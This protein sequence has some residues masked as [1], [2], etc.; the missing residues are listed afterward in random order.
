MGS[1]SDDRPEPGDH[2]LPSQAGPSELGNPNL[3]D[4]PTPA[5]VSVP[6]ANVWWSD[7]ANA[8]LHLQRLR[9]DEV[10]DAAVAPGRA[11]EQRSVQN[12]VHI[13]QASEAGSVRSLGHGQSRALEQRFTALEQM[14]RPGAEFYDLTAADSGSGSAELYLDPEEG[15]S[16]RGSGGART[17]F[18]RQSSAGNNRPL[19]SALGARNDLGI[20]RSASQA[21]AGELYQMLEGSGSVDPLTL[22]L[23]RRLE[24]AE[25][26][27]RSTSTMYSV[28]DL[29]SSQMGKAPM[30]SRSVVNEI[31]RGAIRVQ[32]G[33]RDQVGTGEPTAPVSQ[34]HATRAPPT[35]EIPASSWR[36][37]GHEHHRAVLGSM[38]AIRGTMPHKA[39][40]LGLAVDALR[41]GSLGGVHGSPSFGNV[42]RV[43]ERP[44][45][46]ESVTRSS[47]RAPVFPD[48][49]RAFGVGPGV[50]S[51]AAA[52]YRDGRSPDL[53]AL[54]AAPESTLAGHGVAGFQ[55]SGCLWDQP[56]SSELSALLQE[57]IP[58]IPALPQGSGRLVSAEPL[59]LLDLDPVPI[60]PP[61]LR[62]PESM[63]LIDLLSPKAFM[64]SPFVQNDPE[65]PRTPRVG[66]SMGSVYTPGGT[67]VP[68][69]PPPSTPPARSVSFGP[70]TTTPLP[71]SPIPCP[72]APPSMSGFAERGVT[73]ARSEEPSRLV[74]S[75]PVLTVVEGAAEASVATGDWLARTAPLMRSL[76]PSAPQWWSATLQ[77]ATVYYESWLHSDP[78]QRLTVRAEVNAY[79]KD[80]GALARIEERGSILI[81]QA[82]PAELQSEAISTRAL[83]STAL[84]FMIMTRFQP[85]GGSEKA[86]ILAY[87]TQ[88]TNELGGIAGSHA[89][90]RRWE[91]LYRR[92]KELKLQPPD[93]TLL[94][95]ALESLGKPIASKS[96]SAGFRLSTYR[97]INKLDTLP[98]ESSVLEF[99]QL[100]IAECET[101]LLSHPDKH[102][103]VSALRTTSGEQD[104]PKE[105]PPYKP[106]MKT[107]PKA[108]PGSPPG[109][110]NDSGVCRFF[111]STGGCRY[112]RSC[113]HPHATLSPSDNK[114]F[115][116]GAVGH[117]MTECDRPGPKST[118][119]P[120]LPGSGKV[121]AKAKAD[122]PPDKGPKGPPS[123]PKGRKPKGRKV[124]V[125]PPAGASGEEA[126]VANETGQTDSHSVRMLQPV[127]PPSISAVLRSLTYVNSRGLV[128]G[129]ATHCLRYAAPNEYAHALQVEVQL[130][131]GATCDLRLS[132]VGTLL[133]ADPHVQ[134]ILSMGV[135]A[136]ELG[137]SIHWKGTK[138]EIEHPKRGVL[139]V[140]MSG[141]C[142]E[143]DRDLCLALISEV[144]CKR[145]DSM[146]SESSRAEP[147]ATRP[148][149]H[150]LVSSGLE[151]RSRMSP[152]VACK[153]N[154][155]GF[156][157][158]TRF[159]G[160]LRE[161]VTQ[162]YSDL[163]SRLTQALIPAKAVK[164]SDSGLNRHTRRKLQRGS[165]MINVFPG[166]PSWEHP[167]G[168]HSISLDVAKGRDIL[169]D[170]LFVYL[171]EL[172]RRGLVES[173]VGAIPRESFV[174][175]S[176]EGVEI[177]R[178][179][180]GVERFG[181][182]TLEAQDQQRVDEESVRILRCL[183]LSEVA[184]T[185][186]GRR[187]A[188][189]VD[190]T[191]VNKLFL[192]L[193]H[194]DDAEEATVILSDTLPSIWCWPEVQ[195]L[196]QRWG[197]KTA[198][199]HQGMLGA[200]LARPTRILTTSGYLWERLHMLKGPGGCDGVFEASSEALAHVVASYEQQAWCLQLV[201]H[202]RESLVDWAKG[203][204]HVMKE[205]A[206]R[207][208][209]LRHLLAVTGESVPV[210][211]CINAKKMSDKARECFRRHCQAG[212]RPW[213]ADCAACLD[214]I[215]V[216]IVGCV[217]PELAA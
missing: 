93:P 135:C 188:G 24:E 133:S 49:S 146:L 118:P 75:L 213:R 202:V 100:L 79:A 57:P 76:S 165:V 196:A 69:G 193:E 92:C 192:C 18:T 110:L 160:A 176:S 97:H 215:V 60:N 139:K 121:E 68:D 147:S 53:W 177:L 51:G 208:E 66:T 167:T 198:Q 210:N 142:P 143:L 136:K 156:V 20:L 5:D 178:T 59:S 52:A 71:P 199:F 67:R 16:F 72:P 17:G 107:P 117:A 81:L 95:R 140:V 30:Y 183:V 154:E 186:L 84:L 137:C 6:V 112:G 131:S 197:L 40:Q 145:A 62:V 179:S 94:L 47:H 87:L 203:C 189:H 138:C 74:Q 80:F 109:P 15:S 8:E 61:G 37:E 13:D 86:H 39:D 180:S 126:N 41:V 35:R 173:L 163:P 3:D 206:E 129:G 9:P 172:A 124:E 162:A 184:F 151:P 134:P 207:A 181:V 159:L 195:D 212:H 148:S 102:Q 38:D 12:E 27:T 149:L 216:L 21:P 157:E 168:K 83:N 96:Q 205:E 98:T 104:A 88:P 114:C 65:T 128:D 141:G 171:L 111:M 120:P 32:Q 99:C 11:G 105:F 29:S 130:A 123:T 161:W 78:L 108:K 200:P 10:L 82:L 187:M 158:Q 31:G 170:G 58:Q 174:V 70:V 43:P 26:R 50:V 4:V 217:T 73:E 42:D 2:A 46:R 63:P 175:T 204:Q 64:G 194:P 33:M 25:A 214:S 150:K 190:P 1:H 166:G 201:M 153:G 28:P 155:Q 106:K 48:P 116:C 45:E 77:Q 44:G 90:L 91:R 55:A 54:G 19:H 164:A 122:P 125:E 115:N 36:L 89:A 119:T 14:D 185:G 209:K 127:N 191:V 103:R 85:G 211:A 7:R 22:V 56:I 113:S 23:I 182:S 152:G 34:G 101:I 144:E 132:T 169:N